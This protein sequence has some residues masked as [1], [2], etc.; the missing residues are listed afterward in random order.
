[1]NSKIKIV[2]IIGEAGSGKDTLLN[3]L[4]ESDLNNKY[5]RVVSYT[6]RKPRANEVNGKDYFFISD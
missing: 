6:T 4:I 2:A 3:A 5:H 1:M